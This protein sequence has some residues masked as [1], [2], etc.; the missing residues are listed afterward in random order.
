M[1][2]RRTEAE[3]GRALRAAAGGQ[4]EPALDGRLIRGRARAEY[5][6]LRGTLDRRR[7]LLTGP[8]GPERVAR[9]PARRPGSGS[10]SLR[11]WPVQDPPPRARHA[12][13]IPA[14]ARG[15]SPRLRARPRRVGTLP[16]E[17]PLGVSALPPPRTGCPASSA[18]GVPCPSLATAAAPDQR[19]VPSREAAPSPGFSRSPAVPSGRRR[20]LPPPSDR[21]A[22]E[23]PK[24]HGRRAASVR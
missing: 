19:P 13:R 10:A 2:A 11:P 21:K 9:C 20:G 5:A 12:A 7:S 8:A 22:R 24:V 3:P 14:S 18:T 15:W 4:D 23:S 17:N 16:P 1:R 6:G